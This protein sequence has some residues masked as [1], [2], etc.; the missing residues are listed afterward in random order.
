MFQTTPSLWEFPEG[1]LAGCVGVESNSI[2]PGLTLPEQ[3]VLNA[4]I[5]A[6]GMLRTAK[7]SSKTWP[8]GQLS[9]EDSPHRL[10][11]TV[12]EHPRRNRSSNPRCFGERRLH[13]WPQCVGI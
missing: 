9:H 3:N 7:W 12:P 6:F 13:S 2:S 4:T 5:A 8:L 10:G 1:L 11:R